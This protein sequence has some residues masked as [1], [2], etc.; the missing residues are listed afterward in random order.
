MTADRLAS[1]AACVIV[2]SALACGGMPAS[3]TPTPAAPAP[4][5]A[6]PLGLA[7]AWNGTGT[8]PQGAERMSWMLTQTGAAVSG[9]ADLAPLNAADGS[10]ASCHKFKAGTI[11]G[12]LSGTTLNMTLVFPSGGDGV[13][14]PM[15]T[16]TFDAAASGV[17]GN[18]IAA[19][20][21]GD[22]SCEGRFTG[23]TFAMTR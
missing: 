1:L 20:Y 17:D 13:P 9:T 15:C 6:A 3:P 5:P 10:C 14:T 12:T 19:T 23:G 21:I 2:S 7:G 22:D 8:D 16:I 11:T 18:R 4:T